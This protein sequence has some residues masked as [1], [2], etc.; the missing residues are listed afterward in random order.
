[1]DQHLTLLMFRLYRLAKHQPT[2][3]KDVV[4]GFLHLVPVL[5]EDK[6]PATLSY[7]ELFLLFRKSWDKD[8]ISTIVH[9]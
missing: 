5:M 9:Y 1:M 3:P 7:P 4:A 6:S 2:F 8:G